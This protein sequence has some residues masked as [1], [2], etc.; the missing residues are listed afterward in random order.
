[1]T[2]VK[3]KIS[4]EDYEK[5]MKNIPSTH[6][7]E[8]EDNSEHF[9]IDISIRKRTDIYSNCAVFYRIEKNPSFYFDYDFDN[10]ASYEEF[11]NLLQE[12]LKQHQLKI[13]E[14]ETNYSIEF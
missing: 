1:M 2:E 14:L 8:N 5:T 4:K 3:V 7:L 9:D 11:I 10:D 13:I 6:V 12:K